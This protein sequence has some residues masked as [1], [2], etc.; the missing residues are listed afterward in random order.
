LRV[1]EIVILGLDPRTSCRLPSDRERVPLTLTLS[2][3]VRGEVLRRLGGR[4]P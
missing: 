3:E 2:P 1:W 4:H